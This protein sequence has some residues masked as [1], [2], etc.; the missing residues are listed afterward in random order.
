MSRK[1]LTPIGVVGLATAPAT[2][3]IGDLYYNTVD[4]LMYAYNGTA[5][6]PSNKVTVLDGGTPTSTYA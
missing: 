3:S 2:A 1:F 6:I 5:W 4:K